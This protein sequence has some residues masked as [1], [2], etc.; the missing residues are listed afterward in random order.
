MPHVLQQDITIPAGTVF[1]KPVDT[2]RIEPHTAY[3]LR[4][5]DNQCVTLVCPIDE[6][7][8]DLSTLFKP[9]E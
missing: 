3:I 8:F 2:P 6:G 7:S 9:L 5:D 4:L 1:E